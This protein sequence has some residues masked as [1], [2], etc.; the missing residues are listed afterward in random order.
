MDLKRFSKK[1]LADILDMIQATLNCTSEPALKDL[2]SRV[3]EMVCGDYA[4]CGLGECNEEELSQIKR[5]VNLNYPTEWLSVYQEKKLYLKD[6]IIWYQSKFSGV[7]LWSET[8]SIFKDKI[9]FDFVSDASD[10]GLRYGIS[11]GL[12]SPYNKLASIITFASEK[13]HFA[14][15]QKAILEIVIP[16]LHQALARVYI[17]ESRN[18]LASLTKREKEIIKWMKEGKTN[19]EIS[20]ILN[21]SERTAKFHV[22]NIEKKLNAVNKAHAIAIAYDR[23]L[24]N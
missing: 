18:R 9:S 17:E 12:K 13:D 2:L 1:E 3:R 7:Q 5:I 8:Y 4:I 21:I 6:P 11:G 23:G 20:V 19:W 24:V 14:P 22:Q 15:H 16:H 10:F